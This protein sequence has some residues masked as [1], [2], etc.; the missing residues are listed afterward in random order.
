MLQR[1]KALHKRLLTRQE[2]R[3]Q[4]THREEVDGIG[5]LSLDERYW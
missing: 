4:A 1:F 3:A 2:K 5:S